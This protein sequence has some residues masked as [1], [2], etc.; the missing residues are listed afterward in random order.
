[1]TEQ[2]QAAADAKAAEDKKVADAKAIEDAR[3]GDLQKEIDRLQKKLAAKDSEDEKKRQELLA[4]QGKHKELADGY[5]SQ[6]DQLTPELERLRAFE[7]SERDALIAK[8]PEDQ[9]GRW[10]NAE[11]ALLKDHV[12]VITGKEPNPPDKSGGSNGAL[13]LQAQLEAAQKQMNT[14]EIVRLKREIAE[15]AKG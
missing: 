2:E 3:K 10:A 7:K 8:L 15:K 5:K 6:L 12:S 9:R 13:S 4:E 11:L 14:V 1:M